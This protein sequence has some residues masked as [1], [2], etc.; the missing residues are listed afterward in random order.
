MQERHFSE[1]DVRLVYA[2]GEEEALKDGVRYTLTGD[3]PSALG[4]DLLHRFNRG[5]KIILASGNILKTVIAN[6][7]INCDFETFREYAL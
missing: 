7:E 5:R 4:D 2:Y 1:N 3:V 6:D